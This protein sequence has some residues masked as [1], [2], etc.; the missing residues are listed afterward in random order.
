MPSNQAK[1]LHWLRQFS[2]FALIL[3]QIGRYST[4]SFILWGV[5]GPIGPSAQYDLRVIRP[6]GPL[7]PRPIGLRLGPIGQRPIGPNVQ[8]T[9]LWSIGL[10][11][12]GQRPIGLGIWPNE[13]LARRAKA[14]GPKVHHPSSSSPD[15]SGQLRLG[16]GDGPSPSPPHSKPAYHTLKRSLSVF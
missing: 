6:Y 14:H 13:P 12:K 3:S 1:F 11:A 16:L 4:Y 2:H 15:P 10:L 5:L 9:G 8:S 7:G